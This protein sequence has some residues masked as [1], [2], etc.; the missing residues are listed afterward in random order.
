MD[1]NIK[2]NLFAKRLSGLRKE[3]GISQY[4][5]AELLGYSRGL[6]GNY[7][8]GSRQP[9]YDTLINLCN[10]FKV[11]VD[12]MIGNSELKGCDSC[13]RE[14]FLESEEKELLNLY[15]K[16]PDKYKYQITGEING[17]L[18]TLNEKVEIPLEFSKKN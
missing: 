7:E 9:D 4:K 2:K 11:T 10:F 1:E 14:I 18:K 6:I 3:M 17:I 5:L 13:K 16:L 15:R 12:Y 8:Q